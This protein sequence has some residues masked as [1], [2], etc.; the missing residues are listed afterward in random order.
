[1]ENI[2]LNIFIKKL[3]KII[4]RQGLQAQ[5]SHP[6]MDPHPKQIASTY[7]TRIDATKAAMTKGH[8]Y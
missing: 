2:Q 7:M 3:L 8:S 6:I 5:A 1:M 4:N